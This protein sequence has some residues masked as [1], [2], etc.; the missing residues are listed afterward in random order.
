VKANRNPMNQRGIPHNMP[1]GRLD[2][3][4]C[5][6]VNM[7]TPSLYLLNCVEDQIMNMLCFSQVSGDQFF[8][9]LVSRYE[10][11]GLSEVA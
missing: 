7:H 1:P 10:T 2:C 6:L 11:I 3:I 8:F 5:K 9:I 4:V